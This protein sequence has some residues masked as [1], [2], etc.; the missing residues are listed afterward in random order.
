MTREEA[1]ARLGAKVAEVTDVEDTKH[2]PVATTVDGHRVLLGEDE[3]L[4]YGYDPAKKAGAGG[5]PNPG[6]RVFVP[7]EE[8]AEVEVPKKTAAT[9]K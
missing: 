1:A 8:P 7:G 9:K 2:G 6:F 4:W 5:A 3:L